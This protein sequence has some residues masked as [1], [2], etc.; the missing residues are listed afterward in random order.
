[1]RI[2]QQPVHLPGPGSSTVRPRGCVLFRERI[3]LEHRREEAFAAEFQ[4]A[5]GERESRR[6]GWTDGSRRD[7]HGDGGGSACGLSSYHR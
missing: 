6:I 2:E 3:A 1:M 5:Q 7:G 4:A